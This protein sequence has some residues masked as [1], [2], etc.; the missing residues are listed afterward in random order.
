MCR[1]HHGY[2]IHVSGCSQDRSHEK[3]PGGL[4]SSSWI[5]TGTNLPKPTCM[6]SH[7]DKQEENLTCVPNGTLFPFTVHYFWPEVINQDQGIHSTDAYQHKTEFALHDKIPWHI[8]RKVLKKH[9]WCKNNSTDDFSDP[10]SPRAPT[11][12]T[13][14]CSC[15]LCSEPVQPNYYFNTRTFGTHMMRMPLLVYVVQTENNIGWS[16]QNPVM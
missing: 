10:F 14:V 12:F 6:R 5:W 16:L 3:P 7:Y 15:G 8:V 13:K 11:W 4:G 2:F 1:T 9:H